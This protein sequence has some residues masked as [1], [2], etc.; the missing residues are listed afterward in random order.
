[1]KVSEEPATPVI[2]VSKYAGSR[3]ILNGCIPTT[4]ETMTQMKKVVINF[5]MFL[6]FCWCFGDKEK[7]LSPSHIPA[8]K[9]PTVMFVTVAAELCVLQPTHIPEA[10]GV[11]GLVVCQSTKNPVEYF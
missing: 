5:V 7:V 4:H 2:W 9:A 6:C 10:S 3:F 1:M 11:A 8:W